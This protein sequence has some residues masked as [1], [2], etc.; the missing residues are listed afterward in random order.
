MEQKLTKTSNKNNNN[1]NNNSNK[2]KEKVE[3][4]NF[5]EFIFGVIIILSLFFVLMLMFFLKIENN[6]KNNKLKAQNILIMTDKEFYS[7]EEAIILFVENNSE[8][9]IY[10][11]PC[12]YQNRFEKKIDG[13]WQEIPINNDDRVYSESEFNRENRVKNCSIMLPSREKGLYRSIV[14]VFYNCRKPGKEECQ[15]SEIFYSNEFNI[16]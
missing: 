14:Q 11:E 7:S 6:S 10:I 2:K 13:T 5:L 12:M 15:R 16:L 4:S 9:A 8:E 1:N 3:R